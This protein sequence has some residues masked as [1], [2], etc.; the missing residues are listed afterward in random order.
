MFVHESLELC[1]PDVRSQFIF[2][3][4]GLAVTLKGDSK[5]ERCCVADVKAKS[6]AATYIYPGDMIIAISE[7]CSMAHSKA[8]SD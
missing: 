4:R 3:T 8:A 5:E 7:S 2:V 1:R 6:Q